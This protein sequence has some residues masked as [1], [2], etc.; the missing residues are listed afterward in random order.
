MK[1]TVLLLHYYYNEETIVAQGNRIKR[2]TPFL[3]LIQSYYP[4]CSHDL[5]LLIK[6][7]GTVALIASSFQKKI[8]LLHLKTAQNNRMVQ[9]TIETLKDGSYQKIIG[10][11]KVAY[12]Y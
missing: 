4:A 2:L 9:K 1:K 6:D 5:A 10:L 7:F 3:D 11:R 8:L 12:L